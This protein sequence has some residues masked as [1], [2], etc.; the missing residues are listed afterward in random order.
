MISQKQ[1]E[2]F[3]KFLWDLSKLS[4]ASG[5]FAGFMMQTVPIWKVILAVVFGSMSAIA[6]F[7][8]D[9]FLDDQQK[10]VA[11]KLPLRQNNCEEENNDASI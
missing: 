7:V 4:L 11:D 6:A 2:N 5:A 10:D 9:S 3:G 1:I 8:V